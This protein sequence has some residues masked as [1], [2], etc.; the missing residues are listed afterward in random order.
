MGS[1]ATK[2]TS[3]LQHTL[4]LLKQRINIHSIK[5]CDR[6]NI[7]KSETESL[8]RTGKIDLA[9][10]KCQEILL[11]KRE[12]KIIALLRNYVNDLIENKSQL[13]PNIVPEKIKNLV[14]SCLYSTQYLSIVE[15]EQFKKICG[16]KYGDAFVQRCLHNWDNSVIDEMYEYISNYI[17]D[18]VTIDNCLVKISEEKKFDV[19]L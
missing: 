15:L 10:I 18:E 6:I 13:E 3:S 12:E 9:K 2:L 1:G 19:I 16:N 14:S 11:F 17:V 7:L 4:L 8:V 5:T